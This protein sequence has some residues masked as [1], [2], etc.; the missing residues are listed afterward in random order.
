MTVLFQNFSQALE[1]GD[2]DGAIDVLKRGLPRWRP[3]QA[4]EHPIWALLELD[5][6]RLS[7]ADS[8]RVLG[9]LFDGGMDPDFVRD[10]EALGKWN[11][12]RRTTQER[13]GAPLGRAFGWGASLV[14]RTLGLR[15]ASWRGSWLAH[16]NERGVI[17]D[18]LAWQL[19]AGGGH[20]DVLTAW[21]D[22]GHR[23][24]PEFDLV[25]ALTRDLPRTRSRPLLPVVRFLTER[26]GKQEAWANLA[27]T[28]LKK[29]R[30]ELL[31]AA[32]ALNPR[33]A[34][35]WSVEQRQ[36]ALV[37]LWDRFPE[38]TAAIQ[39]VRNDPR[40]A[41]AARTP[42]TERCIPGLAKTPAH[43]A[44]LPPWAALLHSSAGTGASGIGGFETVWSIVSAGEGSRFDRVDGWTHAELRA[45]AGHGPWPPEAAE[46]LPEL[47]AATPNPETGRWPAA[48]SESRHLRD[49][50]EAG[51][52]MAR[53]LNDP[54]GP[55]AEWVGRAVGQ[56][57]GALALSAAGFLQ[58]ASSTALTASWEGVPLRAWCA[59]RSE[60]SGAWRTR[61]G[62]SPYAGPPT[63]ATVQ[64]AAWAGVPSLVKEGIERLSPDE[65]RRLQSDPTLVAGV[66]QTWKAADD[67]D[68]AV[69]KRRQSVLE[70]LCRAGAPLPN[71]PAVWAHWSDLWRKQARQNWGEVASSSKTPRPIQW[72]SCFKDWPACLAS[73]WILL[74]LEG[75][76]AIAAA[77]PSAPWKERVAK[78]VEQGLAQAHPDAPQELAA[79]LC[80]PQRLGAFEDKYVFNRLDPEFHAH[81]LQ[82]FLTCVPDDEKAQWPWQE[83]DK[84]W[85][86]GTE[87]NETSRASWRG[88][89]VIRA[90]LERSSLSRSLPDTPAPIGAARRRM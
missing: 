55:L 30:H 20:D 34:D 47:L 27:E 89:D 51:G 36:D 54:N 79:I 2:A 35:A 7:A 31:D 26:V 70:Y 50:T 18:G 82:T 15:S 66:L 59:V 46:R 21:W 80:S 77:S 56:R 84:E 87:S 45:A 74:L 11:D 63:A 13:V 61:T 78:W 86:A 72:W 41:E 49:W 69:L 28:A 81:A 71:D 75:R 60:L 24:P 83:W 85:R 65:L 90:E 44:S 52:G 9:A 48:A 68:A 40:W 19:A 6:R 88:Y 17:P 67:T 64:A 10:T 14:S 25:A 22:G 39:L 76:N 4:A 42:M 32:L 33:A 16:L 37:Q 43:G 29:R 57:D 1:R 62:T 73:S 58:C 38:G 53:A 5:T 3:H 23:L 8:V 12:L